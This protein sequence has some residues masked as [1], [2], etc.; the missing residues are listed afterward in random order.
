MTPVMLARL[1]GASDF[2]LAEL[3]KATPAADIIAG[4]V[5]D[6]RAHFRRGDPSTLR[7]AG[8]TASCTHSDGAFLLKRWQEK[9][10]VK[11]MAEKADG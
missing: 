3:G 8:V 7:V 6:H 10:T 4:L 1:Q 2:V 11:I 9:A 5:A